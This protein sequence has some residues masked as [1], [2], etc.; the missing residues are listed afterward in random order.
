MSKVG[1]AAY[2]ASRQRVETISGTKEIATA[3]TGELYIV[4]AACAV[5]LP[6]VQNGAYFK[7]I[8]SADITSA[9]ALVVTA[10]GA[11][12]MAGLV[13][14][15]QGTAV[16]KVVQADIGSETLLTLGSAG[17]K[18]LAGSYVEL[19]CDGTNWYA[20]GMAAG[21]N[22]DITTCAFS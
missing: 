4:S 2:A 5:T 8:L 1:R 10:A 19:Y 17:N 22:G 3:E 14:A 13:S 12:K 11:A 16:A 20:T 21:N 9:T 18:V 15:I 7:F 6:A